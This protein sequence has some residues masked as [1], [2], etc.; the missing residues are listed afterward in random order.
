VAAGTQFCE[1]TSA[2]PNDEV[3]NKAAGDGDG[4]AATW[5]SDAISQC[6]CTSSPHPGYKKVSRLQ[7]YQ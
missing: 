7:N 6:T 5:D 1:W 2:R 4:G 3:V